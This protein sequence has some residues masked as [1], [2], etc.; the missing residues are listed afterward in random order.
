MRLKG[1]HWLGLW[2][3]VFLVV[4][5]IVVARQAAALAAATRLRAL[6]ADRLTLEASKAELERRI[7][8]G[9]SLEVLAPRAARL[10]LRPAG[11]SAVLFPVPAGL[12]GAP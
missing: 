1:R 3:L 4:A 7:H 5:G 10:G 12:A 6:R 11:D 8:A 2:L 9:S